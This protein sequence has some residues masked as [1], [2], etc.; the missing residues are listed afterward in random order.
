MD[1]LYFISLKMLK[2]KY[3]LDE[4]PRE[5]F[6][7]IYYQVFGNNKNNNYT[8]VEINDLNKL[9]LKKINESIILNDDKNDK[10]DNKINKIDDKKDNNK[11]NKNDND[12]KNDNDKNDNDDEMIAKIN[13]MRNIRNNMKLKLN[14]DTNKDLDKKLILNK[15]YDIND[16]LNEIEEIRNN[17]SLNMNANTNMNMSIK[18]KTFIINSIKNNFTTNINKSNI[19]PLLLLLP[20]FIKNKTPYIILSISDTYNNN[21]NYTFIYDK[22]SS[23]WDTWKPVIKSYNKIRLENTNW[24]IKLFDF[25]NDPLSLNDYYSTS[26]EILEN[27]NYF[28]IKVD[29]IHLFNLNDKIKIIFSNNYS[30]DN[31]I[32]E[33]NNENETIMISKNNMNIQDFINSKIFN[34]NYQI[35]FIFKYH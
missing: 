32:S 30:T 21:V 11:I 19:Y 14:N 25:N 35:S 26:L 17:M 16:K 6:N 13:E 12:D 29:K 3:D 27:D 34:Y 24:N 22:N 28:N 5:K 10:N 7:I 2:D 20:S 31:I 1:K 23:I 18:Y 4:Y 15:D 9:V 33:I 8:N